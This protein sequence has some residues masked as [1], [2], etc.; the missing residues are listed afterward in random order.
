MTINQ[1]LTLLV[2]E[3]AEG[4]VP[5]PLAQRFRLAFVWAD[6]ARLAGEPLPDHIAAALDEPAP[7]AAPPA[8]DREAYA[9]GYRAV[10]GPITREPYREPA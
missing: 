10:A 6:L 7:V 1:A 8:L 9:A 2:A 4:D 3:L 5:D